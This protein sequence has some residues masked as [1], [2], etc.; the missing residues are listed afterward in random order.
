MGEVYGGG[1]FGGGCGRGC[2]VSGTRQ[3][4]GLQGAWG[5][6]SSRAL[7]FIKWCF[8]VTG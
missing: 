3:I 4:L 8:V 7:F 6:D 2:G 5:R 1:L